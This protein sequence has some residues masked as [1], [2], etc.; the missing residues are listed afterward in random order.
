MAIWGVSLDEA[1]RVKNDIEKIF[2][3][4]QSNDKALD[5]L[6]KGGDYYEQLKSY[7]RDWMRFVETSSIITSKTVF[8]RVR[9]LEAANKNGVKSISGLK[10]APKGKK[11]GR[12]NNHSLNVMY[13]SY[14]EYTAISECRLKKDDFF[15]LTRFKSKQPLKYFE[16]G[17][18]SKLYF[19]TPRDSQFFKDQVKILFGVENSMDSTVRGFAALESALMDGLYAVHDSPEVSYYLSS[20]IADAIFT[21]YK[22]VDAIMFPS[23][24][25]RFGINLSFKESVADNLE[26]DYTCVNQITNVYKTGNYKYH[27]TLE[28]L[29]FTKDVLEYQ[30]VSED[31][32]N[33]LTYTCR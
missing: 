31:L 10:Y 13:A 33:M 14:H 19:T 23:L 16:L 8:Y 11:F 20:I 32:Y 5:D 21:E 18:F 3:T 30:S 29:D 7:F 6:A 22:D 26:V 27:T 9:P 24:Q 12:M 17:L 25:Q 15:Q 2:K 4:I 28:C 1:E